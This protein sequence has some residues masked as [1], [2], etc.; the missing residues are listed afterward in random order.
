MT[1]V[2]TWY[3]Q[4]HGVFLWCVSEW[5]NSPL[6]IFTAEP[7]GHSLWVSR[8]VLS[9]MIPWC[10]GAVFTWLC[11]EDALSCQFWGELRENLV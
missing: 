1:N 11:V 4:R 10:H 7:L 3:V 2:V 9:P 5:I 8:M 6:G